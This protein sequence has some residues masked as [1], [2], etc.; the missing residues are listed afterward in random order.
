MYTQSFF[1]E[2]NPQMFITVTWD[3]KQKAAAL[4]NTI[5]APSQK[6]PLMMLKLIRLFSS[7]DLLLSF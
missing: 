3:K 2:K 5:E 6:P 1:P 4:N 7:M